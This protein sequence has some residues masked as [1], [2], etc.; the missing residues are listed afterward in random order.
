M[1]K[2]F[3][4]FS[5]ACACATGAFADHG[6]NEQWQDPWF[7]GIGANATASSLDPTG[8]SWEP[9]PEGAT[10]ENKKLVLDLDDGA[11][12]TFTVSAAAGDTDTIVEV[13]AKA[14]FYPLLAADLQT[15]DLPDGAKAAFAVV[16]D[17]DALSYRALVAGTNEWVTLTGTPVA[18]AETTVLIR[19]ACEMPGG[20]L[21]R[22]LRIDG[23]NGTADLCPIE[24]FDGGELKLVMTL[25]EPAGGR[26]AGRHEISFGVQTDRY[27]GQLRELAAIVRGELADTADYEHDLRVH[28][29]TLELLK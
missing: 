9:L 11:A 15:T 28:A 29:L 13:K 25:A 21:C 1:K 10:I 23:S 12:A 2:P 4:A 3:I 17:G 7:T 16:K 26:D 14:V 24:R 6:T 22:R 19:T 5:I 18:D 20:I 27:A 8:G